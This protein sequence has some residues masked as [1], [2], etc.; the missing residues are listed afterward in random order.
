MPRD[1][2]GTYT[3]PSNSFYPAQANTD[4]DPNDWNE[5]IQ[6]IGGAITDSALPDL[7][8]LEPGAFQAAF[9]SSL[10]QLLGGVR[11]ATDSIATPGSLVGGVR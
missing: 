8:N 10:Q 4:V 11:L 1:A 2:S 5:T 9:S 3:P 7:S 6:D